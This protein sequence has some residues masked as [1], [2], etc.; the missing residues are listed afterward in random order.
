MNAGFH[1]ARKTKMTYDDIKALAAQGESERLELKQ[2]TNAR[3]E[4]TRA[5]CAMLNQ[6][7]GHVVFGVTPSGEVKGQEV[8]EHT[9][10]K[11][12]REV[13]SID[14]QP[15]LS[16]Q[17]VAVPGRDREVLY[18]EVA[19]GR[20]RPYR[21]EGQ[22]YRRV[23]NSTI[24][25]D[26]RKQNWLFLESEHEK[27]RWENQPAEGWTIDDLDEDRIQAIV[28]M[29]LDKHRLSDPGERKIPNLL[30]RLKVLKDGKLLRAAAVLFGKA[31]R[32]EE[33]MPQCKLRIGRIPNTEQLEFLDNRQFHGNAFDLLDVAM[34]YLTK[35]LPIAGRFDGGIRR[36]DIPAYPPLAVRE[37]MAN[38]L[39]HRDYSNMTGGSIRFALYDDR[40]EIMSPGPLHFDM[41]EE[42]LLESHDSR[43]WNPLIAKVF[44]RCGI[45]EEWG[46]GISE[47]VRQ[48]EMAGLLPPRITE[49]GENVA[50]CF[51]AD[52]AQQPQEVEQRETL[53][54]HD[55][56][57]FSVSQKAV[58]DLLE[59]SKEPMSRKEILADLKLNI[60]DRQLRRILFFLKQRGLINSTGRSRSVLWEYSQN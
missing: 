55:M 52:A 29:S 41:D 11:L 13:M 56:S 20:E 50:V 36:I 46:I 7:G 53:L 23:G 12:S 32:L 18:I 58:L 60:S 27:V 44:Y 16:V 6:D 45:I 14:P 34:D 40:L 51:W 39:C 2:A 8:S 48:V 54:R 33:D 35:T 42:K 26:S 9:I 30:Q 57:G 37:A 31:D 49:T 15:E 1:R 24:V 25:L 10:E 28:S 22:A 19:K 59:R 38:A 43:P 21:Y 17:R 4:A 3:N 47:M 5:V